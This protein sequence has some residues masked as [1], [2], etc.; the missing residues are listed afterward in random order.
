MNCSG[1]PH[2]R[3]LTDNYGKAYSRFEF[4][5]HLWPKLQSVFE[6]QG[7]PA[8]VSSAGDC[9]AAKLD[10]GQ[11]TMLKLDPVFMRVGPIGGWQQSQDRDRDRPNTLPPDGLDFS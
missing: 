1:I 10:D 9:I 2:F 7:L 8:Q 4:P 5:L 11:V 6:Q 3:S